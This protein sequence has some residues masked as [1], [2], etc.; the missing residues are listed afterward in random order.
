M[1]SLLPLGCY[2]SDLENKKC[3]SMQVTPTTVIDTGALLSSLN[4]SQL[5]EIRNII[6]THSHFDHI[7]DLPT[8]S[9]FML[10]FGRH[11]FNLYTTQTIMGELKQNILNDL[12]WPDFT[13]LPNSDHP[14][15]NFVPIE[16]DKPFTIDGT[17]FIPIEMNHLV[18]SIGFIIRKD[19]KTFAYSGDTGV[20]ENFI[21]HINQEPSIRTLCWETS[22]PNRLEN[23][24]KVSKHLSPSMLEKELAKL[25]RKYEVHLF[26]LK[27]NLEDEIIRDIEGIRTT[28][29]LMTMKQKKPVFIS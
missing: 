4:T 13:K 23:L 28:M 15:I 12:I 3:I 26:H 17:E 24:A 2:G 10:S 9:D 5:L 18:E 6:I 20:C 22:F 21:D 27:P 11:R 29:N 25:K 8:F 14:T 16:F 19:G 7:K 1:F